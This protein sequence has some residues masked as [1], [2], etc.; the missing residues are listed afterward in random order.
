[1]RSRVPGL[2]R[3]RSTD[4]HPGLKPSRY[5]EAVSGTDAGLFDALF[6]ACAR[7]RARDLLAS[8]VDMAQRAGVQTERAF[9]RALAGFG[10]SQGARGEYWGLVQHF[11]NH[12]SGSP[13]VLAWHDR[14]NGKGR[15]L[16]E[17]E[18]K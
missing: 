8:A 16:Y 1:M 3:L 10:C 4:R 12:R 15:L 13:V 6:D 2:L 18:N 7:A 9:V 11:R 14:L 5:V 17:I